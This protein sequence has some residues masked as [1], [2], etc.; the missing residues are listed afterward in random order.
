M[1]TDIRY[2]FR[3]LQ[4]NP[5]F[6]AVAIVTLALGI[7]A[8]TAIFSV[9]HGVLLRPLPYP[10]PDRVVQVW[11]TTKDAPRESH[12]AA[13]FLDLKRANRTLAVLAGFRED[14]IT[15]A[16]G[17]RDPIRVAGSL[18]TADF[19][20]VFG[21]SPLAGR[22]FSAAVDT[23]RGEP[24]VVISEGMWTTEFGRDPSI[25]GRRVRVNTAPHTI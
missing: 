9:V 18:V 21:M 22:T 7:G 5:G 13:D 6:A 25:V 17:D 20:E 11:T 3:N 1:G 4:K 8:T 2:A 24:L 10:D 19:F 12:A 16:T 14:A 23:E 15:I